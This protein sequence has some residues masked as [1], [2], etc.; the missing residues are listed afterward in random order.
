VVPFY[1]A[2]DTIPIKDADG[3]LQE[4]GDATMLSNGNIV[5][6]RKTGASEVT[7]DK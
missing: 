2:L 1:S 4:L 7:P 5:F 3:T 6:C